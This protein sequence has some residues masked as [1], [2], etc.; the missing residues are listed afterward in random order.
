MSVHRISDYLDEREARARRI[1]VKKG[2]T[3]AAA[4]R[5]LRLYGWSELLAEWLAEFAGRRGESLD[6]V[7]LAKENVA[8][9]AVRGGP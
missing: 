2:C 1:A 8:A 6:S 5:A 4:K 3:V 7:C 9:Y